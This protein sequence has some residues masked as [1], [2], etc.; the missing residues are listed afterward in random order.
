[1]SKGDARLSYSKRF[2]NASP[3]AR[4]LRRWSW[5]GLG[6]ALALVAV[7]RGREA[8]V[9]A[10]SSCGQTINPIE[11]EN[12]K[13]GAPSSEWDIGDAGDP[14]IQGFATEISVVPGQV[15]R[16]KIDTNASSYAIDIYRMG[17][18]GGMGARKVASIT[19]SASLPQSQPDCLTSPSTGLI[20]CGNWAVSA[21]WTVPAGSTSGIYF[22]KLQ[23]GDTGGESHIVFIVR[24]DAGNSDLVFQTSDTTWQAYNQYGGNSLYV[25]GPGTSPGRAYKVSYNR[26][27]TTRS[28]SS[29]DFVFNAEYPMVRWL[30]ANGFNV[31]YISGVDTDRSGATILTPS[32]HKAFLSVGHDEYWSGGQRANVE[33][34][35]GAG[36]HLAFFSGNE[37]FWKTRWENSIDGSNTPY[38]TLVCYKET[39]ANGRIDPGDPPTWTGTWRDPRFSPPSDGGRPENALTGTIFKVNSG[40][41]GISVPAQF[42]KARFWRNTTVATLAAGGVANMPTGTLGYEWDEEANNGARPPGLMRLSQKTVAGVDALQDYGSTYAS[43]TVTHSLTMYRHPS[44]ALVFGAGSVQWSW[45]L[46]SN[47]DRGNAAA[48]VRMQQATVNLFADMGVQPKTLQAGLVSATA[49]SDVF[50]PQSTITSPTSGS[51]FAAGSQIAI[52]GTATDTGGGIVAGVEVSTDGGVTWSQASGTTSWTYNWTVSGTGNIPIQSRAFDDSGNMETPTTGVTISVTAR[53]CPCSIWGASVPPAPLDSGDTASVELGTK[54][55]PDND[56]FITG[57]RFYKASTN[58]GTHTG[59]LWTRT[60]MLLGTVTFANETASGWQQAAFASP[61]AITAGTTYVVSYHA[62]NGHYTGTDGLF[63]VNGVD[64]PPL[65]ALRDGVDGPNGLYLYGSAAAFPTNTF[66]SESYW[67]DVVFT[68]T[69]GVD[70][71]PPTILSTTPGSGATGVNPGG[72]VSITFSEAVDSSTVSS[73]TVQL[74][75]ASSAL[76]T[77]TLT[78]DAASKTATL[79]PS[80]ALAASSMYTASVKGGATDPRV[81]DLAANALAATYTWSFTT[82]SQTTGPNCPC[83][84]WASSTVPTVPDD[85]DPAAVE[86]GTKFRSDVA[87]TISGARFYKSTANTGTHVAHLWTSTGTLLATTTFSNETASGWQQVSFPTAVPISANT[88]YVVSYFAPRG[89]YAGPDNYFQTTGVDNAPLHALRNGVDGPN[90]VYAYTSSGAFPTQTY[91]SE[92][93]FVDV[94]LTT[95][96]GPT[97]S[98]SG[99]ITPAASASGATVT[100]TGGTS[101]TTT[102]D[103]S[104]NFTFTGLPNGTYTVTPTKTGFTFAPANQSVTISGANATATFTAQAATYSIS[105]ALTLAASGSGAT[106]ALSGSATATTTADASGNYTFSGLANG[107]YTVTPSKTGFTFTPANRAVT[108]SSANVTANFTAQAVT[109]A[110]SGSITP[111]ASGSGAT[112][113]LSGAGTG[114]TTADASGNF[115]FNGLVNGN[116]TLTPSKNGFTF[117]PVTQAITINGAN[118]TAAFATQPAP[119]FAIS[120]TIT[121]A[122]SGSGA[123]VALSGAASGSTS[124]DASGTYTFTGLANGTYTVT[125]S[126]SGF[127]FTPGSQAVVLN[128]S[129]GTANF[130]A[131]MLPTF[132]ISGTVTPAA[133]GTGVTLNLTGGAT[134][135]TSTDANGNYAFAGLFNGQY[136]VTPS[137]SGVSF[138]P[139]S[140][141]V[142]IT[143]ANVTANFTA[144]SGIAVDAVAPFGRSTA[145]TTIASPAFSTTAPNELFLAFIAS[146]RVSGTVSVSSMTGASL[147]WQLVR[148]TN[149]QFG[150]AEIW[151]AFSTTTKSNVTVTA[152]LSQSVAAAITVVTLSGVDTTGTNGSGAIGATASGSANS[153]APT[154]TLV[155][156]RANSLV[157]GVGNDWDNGIARTLGPNQTSVSQYIATVGDTFWVQ[158]TTAAVSASG[159]NVTINATS[160]TTDRYNLTI[161]EIR[162]P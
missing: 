132:T 130:A 118:G 87:G 21:S 54:F 141:V 50:A 97:F 39:H 143:V 73:S 47:H 142:T 67:V 129:N 74:Q 117:A 91:L 24:D 20:D 138:A 27:I 80:S 104:G 153:G 57:V 29:E 140:Q 8:A 76:V 25:G 19:P 158:R 93:Y 81:K 105:G 100:L 154:A 78:Y 145:S 88:T 94:V 16:F 82:A 99:T 162:T 12:Q 120:G 83:S 85:G 52:A 23:R 63:F 90:G 55:R 135:S 160:P 95:A 3:K 33:A 72:A 42:G 124:A 77:A 123:I 114:T 102:A 84:I 127:S 151:R 156:T 149:A 128:G 75:D 15:E 131:Q 107:N 122:S 136:T 139:A 7:S 61:I 51:S 9:L 4:V 112:V 69:L 110:I 111:A 1:M 53:S 36:L 103:A 18:Y 62:P 71:T 89:H 44:G 32:K 45:G 60:G 101:A 28:T 10:Q 13:P 34:A 31:S 116:Y 37:V 157:F 155:T 17:Y 161:C 109:Y 48:D 11:C 98:L 41:S 26:P 14:S 49:S 147:T 92:S 2:V 64:T 133:L 115:A 40:T 56:G 30:E 148:R 108:I 121:P 43:G 126:K 113:V 79:T 137:K 35:R 152:T 46:D 66:N 68:T 86:I 22:A 38:R 58:T 144:S 134:M 65:H 125:P 5:A 96:T 70:T 6:I 159:A 150:T 119:T 59:S 106:V 146:D